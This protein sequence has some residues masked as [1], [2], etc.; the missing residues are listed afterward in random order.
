LRLGARAGRNSL[1][2]G[3]PGSLT[4]AQYAA[5]PQQ[6]NN[7]NEFGSSKK[8]N[9][10]VF[11]EASMGDWQLAA[12]ANQRTK[13]YTSFSFG[14][15]YGYDV[16]ASNYSVRARH[17]GK[18]GVHANAFVIGYDQ[19]DWD[20]VITQSAF[21]PIG[22]QATAST[23]AIYLKDDL[24]LASTG[25]R[26]SIGWRTEKLEKTEASSTSSLNDRQHAWDLGLS[27][28]VGKDVTVSGCPM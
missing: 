13:K 21:T 28:P 22:T 27:Q 15:P 18:L 9:A 5:N 17:E 16:D 11:A 8:D 25:T 23:S 1:H 6:A 10:G 14:S 7:T 3:L 2:S 26:L 12:D 19:G 24:T 4:A 20:R